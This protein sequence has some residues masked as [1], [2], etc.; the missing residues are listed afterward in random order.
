[1]SKWV[2]FKEAKLN[3][4]LMPS[5]WNTKSD[6]R[7]DSTL[8]FFANKSDASKQLNQPYPFNHYRY[9]ASPNPESRQIKIPSKKFNKISATAGI[10]MLLVNTVSFRY[11]SQLLIISFGTLYTFF[12]VP[13]KSPIMSY[14]YASQVVK[15]LRN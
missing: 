11:L 13:S 5:Y 7:N 10:F 15:L 4:H 6:Q 14:Q 8:S 9:F 2:I 3:M 1:V 12:H